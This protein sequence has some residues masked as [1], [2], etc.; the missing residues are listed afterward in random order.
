[1]KKLSILLCLVLCSFCVHSQTNGTIN[2][3]QKEVN[4]KQ[5]IK[6]FPNPA[7]NVVNVLGLLNSNR[8]NIAITDTYGNMVLQHHW[9]I[10][11]KAVSIPIAQL[12]QGIYIITIVSKE[13]K[14][15]T[16]FYKK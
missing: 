6:V 9:A 5:K 15:Q 11:D 14:V 12:N 2:T 10:K 1:M 4:I 8:A 13:Q 7:T 3:S 16:K